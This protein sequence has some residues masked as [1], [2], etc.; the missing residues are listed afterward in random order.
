MSSGDVALLLV[1]VL[2]F[3]LYVAAVLS[4]WRP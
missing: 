1:M 4:W 3:I 2:I